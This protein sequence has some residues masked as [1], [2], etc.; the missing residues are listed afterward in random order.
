M[1]HQSSYNIPRK[2]IRKSTTLAT[3]ITLMLIKFV[4]NVSLSIHR[5]QS[6][7]TNKIKK[8][9]ISLILRIDGTS[10]VIQKKNKNKILKNINYIFKN[11]FSHYPWE[12]CRNQKNNKEDEKVV[13]FSIIIMFSFYFLYVGTK[14]ASTSTTTTILLCKFLLLTS[15]PFFLRFPNT[16]YWEFFSF[17]SSWLC[18]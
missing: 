14:A 3:F 16:Y 17:S 18:Q 13:Y 1:E 6:L 15:Y 12:L 8:L 5:L 10:G 11:K 4:C 7:Q 9:I 2:V